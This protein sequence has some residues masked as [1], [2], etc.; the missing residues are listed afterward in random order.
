[1]APR[2]TT[3]VLRPPGTEP[4]TST[5]FW[6]EMIRATLLF[7]MVVRLLP[8]WP[9]IFLPG[10]VRPGVMFVP[11]EP[12]WRLYSCV[13]C[14][15]TKPEKLWRT[16]TPAKPRPRLARQHG[17]FLALL[18]DLLDLDAV[19]REVAAL[20]LVHDLLAPLAERE[21]QGA[22]AVALEGALA[23]HNAR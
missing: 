10:I 4:V 1:M 22:V 23:D 15:R 12:P 8:S 13:P 7:R 16:K 19:L 17:H 20:G 3:V 11:I 2:T 18:G 6:S 21:L 5:R 14:V 9:G